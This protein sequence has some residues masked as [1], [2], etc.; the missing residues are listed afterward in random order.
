MLNAETFRTAGTL[1][2]EIRALIA[3]QRETAA[4]FC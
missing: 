4:L 1:E 3:G 2:Q